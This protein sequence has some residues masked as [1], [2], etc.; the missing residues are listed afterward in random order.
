[1]G[2]SD[3]LSKPIKQ[4]ELFDVIVSAISQPIPE[5]P[6][7]S[8]ARPKSLRTER[9]LRIL[10]A[11]DNQVNQLLARRVLEKLGH[12]V[13]IVSNGLEALSS[14]QTGS[15]DLIAM[16]VQMPEMDGLRATA[17]IREWEKKS[18][19]HIPIIAMTAHAMKEDRERCLAAGMDAYSSKPIRVRELKQTIAELTGRADSGKACEPSLAPQEEVLKIDRVALLAGFDGNRGLL[20]EISEVFLN[21]YTVLLAEIQDAIRAGDAAALARAAHSLKGAIGNFAAK[22]AFAIAQQLE[23]TG[24]TGSVSGADVLW[25][26]L[27]SE[28]A[29]VARDLKKITASHSK[30]Q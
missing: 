13:T 30:S 19:T 17:A 22:D 28:L 15:F 29:L 5:K 23:T 12:K 27:E 25:V 20:H 21:D 9:G 18:G 4:S 1:L 3:Y 10:V 16:D 14:A 8:R 11:E 6:L 2:I 26:M 7:G 24:K